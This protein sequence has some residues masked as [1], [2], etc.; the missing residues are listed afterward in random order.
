MLIKFSLVREAPLS[1]VALCLEPKS[2]HPWPK[3]K[4]LLPCEKFL[5]DMIEELPKLVDA[6]VETRV[7]TVSCVSRTSQSSQ[8][9]GDPLVRT[10]MGPVRYMEKLL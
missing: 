2:C 1:E 3:D 7:G 5:V 10:A 6:L 8:S 9:V 4:T